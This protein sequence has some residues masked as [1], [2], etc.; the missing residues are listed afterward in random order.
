M[1]QRTLAKYAGMTGETNG[2]LDGRIPV[3]GVYGTPFVTETPNE[4]GGYTRRVI[5][6]YTVTRDQ[7]EADPDTTQ[8]KWTHVRTDLTPHIHY[9]VETIDRHQP[10]NYVFFLVKL[11]A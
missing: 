4:R 3:I 2:M 11:G 7:L 1:A 10:L 5:L 9:L 8:R 6:P